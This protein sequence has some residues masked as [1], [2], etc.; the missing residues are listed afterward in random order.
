VGQF[1]NAVG[2]KKPVLD[3]LPEQDKIRMQ[4]Y[5][6]LRPEVVEAI[7]PLPRERPDDEPMF[8]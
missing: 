1:R 3:I 2:Q 4:H 7:A 5:C 6:P 8:N